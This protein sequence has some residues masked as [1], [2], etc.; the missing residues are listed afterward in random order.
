VKIWPFVAAATLV[1]LLIRRRRQLEPTLLVGGALIAV[2]LCVY[3]SGAV[4][5]PNLETLLVDIGQTLGQWTYLLVGALAF[6]ETGAFIGLVAPG[7]TAMMLGGVVAGQGEINVITLIGVAWIAA[8]AGDCASYALGRRLGREFLVKHGARV[9]IGPERLAHVETFFDK[10]GGKAI[11]IGRF[12]GIVRAVAPFLAGSGR[13]PFRRFIPYDVLGAGLWATTFILIGYVFWQSFDRVLKIA[14]E[15]ALGLGIAITVIAGIVW[16]VRWL[17]VAEN[18]ARLERNLD[19]ALDRPGLRM[20][21]PLVHWARGPLRFFVG[22]LTPGQLGLELTTL[23]AVAAV[24][25]FA[26]LGYW[27]LIAEGNAS[28]LDS[29]ANRWAVDIAQPT[30]IDV[31]KVLTVFGAPWLMEPLCAVAAILLL[32]RRRALEAAVIGIGMGMTVA[33]VQI[34]KHA[35]D[36][37]RPG[38]ELVDAA[39]S[40]YPS[41]HSAYA[42]AWIALAVVGMRVVPALRGRW[43]LVVA[44]TVLAALVGLT[45]LYLRVHWVSDVLGGEGAAAMSFSLVAIVALVVAFVRQNAAPEPQ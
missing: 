20:L 41:G 12:V 18:R 35:T 19:S 16:L 39:G 43:W 4:K 23:L 29:P 36:R 40:A 38:N 3:G 30:L 5:L 32:L 24:G 22:R 1:A 11:F 31:A 28:G 7:E 26:F 45:R 25:S 13:M 44:A 8:V 42:M 14:K 15:G 37:A 9:Q 21:R 6:L 34:A 10:H 33:L 2:V 17:Q 27:M